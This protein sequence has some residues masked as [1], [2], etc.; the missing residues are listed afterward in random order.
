[1]ITLPSLVSGDSGSGS[2]C[3]AKQAGVVVTKGL[4]PVSTK[5]LEN[6]HNWEFVELANLL[7]HATLSRSESLSIIQ[8][9]S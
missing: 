2:G 5:L 6:I 1:M 3:P 7:S 8:V 9:A 4:P